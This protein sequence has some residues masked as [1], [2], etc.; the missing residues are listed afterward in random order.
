MIVRVSERPIT[1]LAVGAAEALEVDGGRLLTG[2]GVLDRDPM[3]RLADGS[4][5]ERLAVLRNA[6]ARLV[7]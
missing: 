1:T 7:P 5:E 6:L 2:V 3:L 4:P